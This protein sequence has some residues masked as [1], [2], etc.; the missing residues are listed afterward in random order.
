M[1]Q[2]LVVADAL[3]GGGDG[4]LVEDAP[5]AEV[6]LQPEAPGDEPPQDLQLDLSHEAHMD[7]LEAFVPED[8]ELGVLL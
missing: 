7:L 6:H 3:H 5:R 1:P 8:V 4:L 2:G